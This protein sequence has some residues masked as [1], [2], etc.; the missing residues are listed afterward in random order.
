MKSLGEIGTVKV[1]ATPGPASA[2]D[3]VPY[4]R[5]GDIRS[6]GTLGELS[7]GPVPIRGRDTSL[8]Q[9]DVVVRGRGVPVAA[10]VGA[11]AEGAYPSNDVLVF[12]P[13]PDRAFGAYLAAVLNLPANREALGAGSQGA[14]LSRLSVQVLAGL[15]VPVPD[16]ETQRL[17]A[18]LA[19]CMSA[20]IQLLEQQM[21]MR[22]NKHQQILQQLLANAHDGGGHPHRGPHLAAR[23]ESGHPFLTPTQGNPEM[24]QRGSSSKGG[25]SRHVVPNPEGGWDNKRAGGARA[26]SHH[27]TKQAAVDRAREQ[28]RR[29]GSELVIHGRNG[30]IQAKDS[31]GRDP[32]PPKG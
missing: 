23:S 32:N 21:A 25:G 12:R 20:E 11:S 6:D 26:S 5:A 15:N 27:E 7:L 18:D 14:A 16:L 4:V 19:K 10:S 22:A 29:E 2:G 24:P 1:G 17:I 13:D 9:G 8:H 31:H 28:S 30:Q 3:R